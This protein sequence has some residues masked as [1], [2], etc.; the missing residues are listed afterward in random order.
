MATLTILGTS[1]AAPP[2]GGACS[3]YLVSSDST[4][5]LLDI[6]PGSLGYIRGVVDVHDLDAIFISHM[7][8]DHFLDLLALNVARLTQPG[9]RRA[10]GA[11]VRLPIYLP[12]GGKATVEACFKALQVNVSG[13]TAARY[14]EHLELIEYDPASSLRVNAFEVSF[15][16]P[17]RHSQ[18]DYG[19]RIRSPAGGVLGYTGDTAY[20]EAAIEVGRGADIFLAEATLLEPG[21]QSD[22]HTSAGELAAMAEIA[23][24]AQLVA[25]HFLR[26]DQPYLE[27][28]SARLRA[29]SMP[30]AVAAIGDV[31]EF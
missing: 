23:R 11:P 18:L 24:P 17:T 3:A 14:P 25:T 30:H 5:I 13:T 10:G 19:M 2:P 29:V 28:I 31:F 16:G 4:N 21:A 7:H 8:S 6:G 9:M 1:S 15:V 27:G 12:P 22:T 20:C 26:N